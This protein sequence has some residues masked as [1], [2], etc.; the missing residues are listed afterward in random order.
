[1]PKK[2]IS[3][4]QAER[5]AAIQARR[6][7]KAA[8]KQAEALAGID[9]SQLGAEQPGLLV[10]HHGQSVDVEDAQRRRYRCLLRQNL[11]SLVAG[12]NVVWRAGADQEGVVV[13]VEPRR[14]ALKRPDP[15]GDMKVTAANI[16]QMLIVTAILPALST[17]LLDSYL[18]A[19][20][21]CHIT[22]VI[23][24]N[25][26]DLLSPASQAI[27][28]DIMQIYTELDYQQLSVSAKEAH[29]LDALQAQLV[30]KTS[31]VVGQSGVGKSSLLNRLLPEA[32]IRTQAVSEVG[33]GSHTTSNSQLYHLSCGGEVIDSPGIR[34]FGLWHMDKQAIEQGFVDIAPLREQ[35]K[36]RNCQHQD[37]PGCA[38]IQAVADGTLAASRLESLHKLMLKVDDN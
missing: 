19:A 31:V 27:L 36:F 15:Y 28:D 10:M 2:R 22:P 9:E 6:R 4:R 13:A 21:H 33:L 12:D 30:G 1:M 35:C 25:K 24:L 23:V 3:H 38:V 5:I 29:G 7:A 32:D 37:E 18:V 11:G 26:T 14:N 34:E 17:L 8:A 20:E 16:D